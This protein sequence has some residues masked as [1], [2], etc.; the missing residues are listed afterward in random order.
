MSSRA[1]RLSL[2]APRLVIPSMSPCGHP[3]RSEGS[4]PR[5]GPYSACDLLLMNSRPVI[6][7]E[8][9]DLLLVNGGERDGGV[10]TEGVQSGEPLIAQVSKAVCFRLRDRQAARSLEGGARITL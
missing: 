8:A 2:G 10:S 5:S 9:R 4:V 7:S 3:E 1:P 6:P